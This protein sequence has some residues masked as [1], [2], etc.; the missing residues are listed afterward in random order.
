MQRLLWGDRTC[1]VAANLDIL[2][3]ARE[4]GCEWNSQTFVVSARR[5][6]LKT[7][8]YA[9][10]NGCKW[11]S[12][13]TEAGHLHVLK[14]VEERGLEWEPMKCLEAARELTA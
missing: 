5:G 9:L 2:M 11:T 7:L 10:E 1:A 8:T 14:W 6:N 12:E 13:A 4:N 3:W